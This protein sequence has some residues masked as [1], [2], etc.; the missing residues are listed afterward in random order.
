M[1]KVYRDIVNELKSNPEL[2]KLG[3]G[4]DSDGS[5]SCPSDDN[6]DPQRLKIPKDEMT[7]ASNPK[8][9]RK[10]KP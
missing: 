6:L 7:Q 4:D 1:E 2:I 10:P 5:E 3:D 8:K 9:V